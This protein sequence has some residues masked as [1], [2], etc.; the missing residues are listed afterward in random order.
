MER[1]GK[2]V[3]KTS[4]KGGFP[5]ASVFGERINIIKNPRMNGGVL[6]PR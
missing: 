6:N 5:K 2:G 1:Y 3:G 4:R